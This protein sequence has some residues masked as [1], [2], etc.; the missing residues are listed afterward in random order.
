MVMSDFYMHAAY[1][2]D[3]MLFLRLVLFF[4]LYVFII[5]HSALACDSNQV[6]VRGNLDSRTELTT[7]PVRLAPEAPVTMESE[8]DIDK[9]LLNSSYNFESLL[10]DRTGKPHR[11]LWLF[12]HTDVKKWQI[13]VIS[14]ARSYVESSTDNDSEQPQYYLFVNWQLVFN[15]EGQV[16]S[17]TEAIISPSWEDDSIIFFNISHLKQ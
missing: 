14:E 8:Q 15:D 9:L 1:L 2:K 3:F 13:V 16:I 12:F 4:L 7:V 11:T 10:F 17:P 5:V 6:V